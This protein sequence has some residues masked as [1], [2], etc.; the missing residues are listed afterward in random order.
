MSTAVVIGGGISG[1]SAA[2]Y[3]Q[4]HAGEKIGK[5]IL[6]ESSKRVGGWMNST[7]HADGAI[8]ESG[9]RSLRIVGKPGRNALNL[10]EDLNLEN[11]ILPLTSNNAAA[12]NRYLYVNGALCALPNNYMGFLRRQDPFSRSLLWQFAGEIFKTRSD[13]EDDSIYNFFSRRVS[14]EFADIAVD[15]MCRGIFAGNCRNLSM[16]ACFKDIFNLEK[17]HGSIVLGLLRYPKVPAD[18]LKPKLI[19]KA[20][21]E[22]WASYSFKSGL[23]QLSDTLLDAISNHKMVDIRLSSPVQKMNLK[24]NG[25]I[26]VIT[27]EDEIQADYV[28]SSVYSKNLAAMLNSDNNYLKSHLNAISAVSCA[29]VNL[30]YEGNLLP[31]QAFGHLT[32]SSESGPIL[33]IIYDSC[34]FPSHDS[35]KN[36]PTTRLTVML[37]GSWSE[38]LKTNGSWMSEADITNMATKAVRDHLKISNEPIRSKISLLDNC[39]PQYKVGHTNILSRMDKFIE[40]K[41][42]PL[43]LIGSSYRGVSVN[44]CIL[45]SK[46]A[47]EKIV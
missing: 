31:V 34:L 1:L 4:K 20:R 37:G 35:N 43:Y 13:L 11:E 22:K 36:I 9:P 32:P 12:K 7:R 28:L 18:E 47:V 40:D 5:I 23:Q 42:L 6:L 19:Q 24:D 10:I 16:K 33:G 38:Q 46:L 15:S 45:N 41:N 3:L 21:S 8:Y 17:T 26:S 2:Y 14:K 29:V 25:R 27:D 44:D 39:I 30:E